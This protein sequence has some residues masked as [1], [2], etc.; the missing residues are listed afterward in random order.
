MPTDEEV[1]AALDLIMNPTLPP[2]AVTGATAY[3]RGLNAFLRIT[4][5]DADRVVLQ[6]VNLGQRYS[7][8]VVLSKSDFLSL[9]SERMECPRGGELLKYEPDLTVTFPKP[10]PLPNRF[11]RE[12]PL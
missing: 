2:W 8:G 10:E 12:D 1:W 3:H 9:C 6:P 4:E 5:I 11:E 7:R